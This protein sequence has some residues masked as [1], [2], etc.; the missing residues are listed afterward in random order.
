MEECSNALRHFENFQ[1]YESELLKAQKRWGET[2][3]THRHLWMYA[4]MY[5][6]HLNEAGTAWLADMVRSILIAQQDKP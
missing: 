6:E 5:P 2:L 3:K 1:Q 4:E